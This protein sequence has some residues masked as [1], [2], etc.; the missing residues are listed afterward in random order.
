MQTAE[1]SGEKDVGQAVEETKRAVPRCQGVLDRNLYLLDPTEMV[2]V[3]RGH[4]FVCEQA[5]L[6]E[7]IG[8]S[9]WSGLMRHMSGRLR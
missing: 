8:Y 3:G 5:T 6:T 1:E 4:R 2:A 9:G 7:F